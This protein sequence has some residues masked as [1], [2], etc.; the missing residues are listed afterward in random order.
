MLSTKR[1]FKID[2]H[3]ARHFEYYCEFLSSAPLFKC[4]LIITP[5]L[6]Q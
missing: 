3:L 4:S 6:I 1:Y 2:Q 5:F